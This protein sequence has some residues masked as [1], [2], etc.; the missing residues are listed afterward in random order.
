MFNLTKFKTDFSKKLPEISIG[1]GRVEKWISTGN[2]A[3]NYRISGD[4]F[5]GIPLGKV[6]MFAGESGTGK[7]YIVSGSL[8]KHALK[9][10]CSVILFDTE[11]AIDRDWLERIGLDERDL[12]DENRLMKFAVS[13]INHVSHIV[14]HIIKEYKEN[15]KEN[16]ERMP[17]L[18]I[19]I[20]S[21]GMLKT[22]E[23]I[24]QFEKGD[25]KGDMGRRAKVLKDFVQNV[26]SS[27]AD[28]NI[29][30][31]VT[32]HVYDSMDIFHPSKKISGGHSFIYASSIVVEMAKKVLKNE[33]KKADRI[34]VDCVV[35]KT[36]FTRPYQKISFEIPFDAPL[37]P[38]SGLFDLFK[39]DGIVERNGNR[40]VYTTAEGEE[41]KMFEKDFVANKEL[42][43][44]IMIEVMNGKTT[45]TANKYIEKNEDEKNDLQNHER[46]DV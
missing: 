40:Y 16:R 13:H 22:P 17:D 31:V 43:E 18:L 20:D 2:Y 11:G 34:H 8:V 33:E 6:T 4:F 29:G 21:I 27:I 25:M 42:L 23:L 28:T 37:D 3:L 45:K 46:K 41:I 7:S 5:K 15:F 10:N 38:Y 32:N 36:R 39:D 19:I 26:V 44:K 12:D 9:N 30:M 24:E 14:S 1:L 35:S